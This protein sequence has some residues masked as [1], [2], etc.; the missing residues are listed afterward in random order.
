MLVVDASVAVHVCLS[1]DGFAL[2]G[3]RELV[4]PPLLWSEATSAL[5]ELNWRREISAAL[6]SAAIERLVD[7]PIEL[8]RPRTLVQEAWRIAGELGWAKTYD[9]EYLALARLLECRFLTIDSR[10]K[11]GASRL[12]EIIGPNEL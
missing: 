5:H 1:V 2:L 9:A 10:L 11:R 6:A 12:V 8:R 3:R 7:A 4:A